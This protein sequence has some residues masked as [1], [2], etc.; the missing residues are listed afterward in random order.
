MP[1]EEDAEIMSL[2]ALK[3]GNCAIVDVRLRC[4]TIEDDFG[5]RITAGPEE[6]ATT[7]QDVDR[8]RLSAR[9]R[10]RTALQLK[11]VCLEKQV[12]QN[13]TELSCRKLT[14]RDSGKYFLVLTI[15][16]Q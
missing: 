13:P 5:K 16:Q 8:T 11:L 12:S 9:K 7:G 1:L 10:I 6:V 2:C 14:R 15:L 3:Q 4:C